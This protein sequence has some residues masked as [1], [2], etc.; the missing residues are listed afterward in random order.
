M[1]FLIADAP[2]DGDV[3]IRG[4]D[5]PPMTRGATPEPGNIGLTYRGRM[6]ELDNADDDRMLDEEL[7]MK[8]GLCAM[9]AICLLY[10]ISV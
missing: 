7:P 4:R 3:G 6:A 8:G 5:P 9:V 1:G 2:E 10:W